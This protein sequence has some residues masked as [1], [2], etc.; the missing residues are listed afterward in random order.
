MET[1]NNPYILVPKRK[2]LISR[3]SVVLAENPQKSHMSRNL[4][5]FLPEVISTCLYYIEI[6]KTDIFRWEVHF[7]QWEACPGIQDSFSLLVGTLSLPVLSTS[8]KFKLQLFCSCG[9]TNFQITTFL[10][11]TN[12]PSLEVR[13]FTR[14]NRKPLSPLPLLV[15]HSK[16]Q[17][18]SRE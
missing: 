14:N 15:N 11:K 6:I 18:V 3:S 4:H 17:T 12:P 8:R 1:C 10:P 5:R 2:I 16:E 13:Y 7:C 9:N